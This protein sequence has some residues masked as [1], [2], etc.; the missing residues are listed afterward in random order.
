[1]ILRCTPKRKKTEMFFLYKL[2]GSLAAP[3]GLFVLLLAIFTIVALKTA[4]N[5]ALGALLALFTIVF[6]TMSIPAGA[7]LITGTLESLYPKA[8]PA[9]DED[10]VILVLSGDMGKDNKGKAARLGPLTLERVFAAVGLAK[11]RSGRS[12]LIMSGGKVFDEDSEA[13][14]QIMRDTAEEMGCKD[15]ILLEDKSRTTEENMSE[16]VA[17]I[18][19]LGTENVI[20]VTDA[21]HIP[22]SMIRAKR[23]MPHV[24]IYPYPSGRLTD[25]KIIK[26]SFLPSADSLFASC[27]GAKEWVGIAAAKLSE[28]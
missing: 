11:S 12:V 4:K 28:F 15:K 22:R 2:I 10:A 6:Y 9:S 17:A 7:L 20:I 23:Y 25:P 24:K 18:K 3:P 19:G 21:F 14:A 8:L 1:M 13:A 5:K 26:A 27:L 16:S